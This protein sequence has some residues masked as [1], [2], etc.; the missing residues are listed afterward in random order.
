MDGIAARIHVA[1]DEHHV[2]HLQRAHLFF[3]ERRFQ[4][5][6]AAAE[7][8]AFRLGE[9]LDGPRR[10]AVEPLGD[11]AACGVEPHAQPPERPA[12]VS[13]RN[14]EAGW[15]PVGRGDLAADQRDGP[16]ESHRS[17]ADAVRLAHDPGFE[18]G[19]NRVGVDVIERAEQ[20]LLRQR[21]AVRAVAA[22]AD[23]ER[24]GRAAL[25]LRLPHR[26][27]DALAHAL[28][29]AVRAPKPFERARQR[30]LDVFVLAPAALQDEADLDVRPLPLLEVED[31]R[32]LAQVVA[33]VAAGERIHGVRAQLAAARG[34]GDGLA[35]RR[36]DLDLA[37]PKR[38][39]DEERGHAGVL[40]D[41][42]FAAGGHVHV[43]GDNRER[44]RRLRAWCFDGAGRR[45]RR[46]HVRRQVR[47]SLGN[48][49]EKA[50]LQELH[51][52]FMVAELAG[53]RTGGRGCGRGSECGSGCL[54]CR[55]PA[56]N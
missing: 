1:V 9:P 31:R 46:A 38:R 18:F 8:E 45:H 33:A 13:H 35:N 6:L 20:L 32:S 40:A 5:D 56:V 42:I 27:Q 44:L 36:A 3:R 17:Y 51:G 49:I 48:Q 54:P 10:I 39:A 22:D 41:W 24:P 7:R 37:G 26:V 23:A 25:P 19:Q 30:I 47:G 28:Q 55:Q 21:V 4:V 2:A 16:A 11:G 29:V 15:K 50:V 14:E 52:V 12:L 34:F 43:A 53:G